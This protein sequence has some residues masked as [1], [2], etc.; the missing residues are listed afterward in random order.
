MT[1]E[2]AKNYCS[3]LTESSF[4]DWRLPNID[5]LRTLIQNCD[6]TKP[7][8]KCRISENRQCLDEKCWSQDCNGCGKIN[9]LPKKI[10]KKEKKKLDIQNFPTILSPAR[11]GITQW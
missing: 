8:G 7:G 10:Y 1:W 11:A 2:E 4:S 6:K 5:E 9:M 3:D